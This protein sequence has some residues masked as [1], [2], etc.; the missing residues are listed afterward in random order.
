MR[1]LAVIL[2]LVFNGSLVNSQAWD[3]PDNFR[4][5]VLDQGV[6]DSVPDIQS[7]QDYQELFR[8]AQNKKI[9]GICLSVAGGACLIG[10]ISLIRKHYIEWT[11]DHTKG[12]NGSGVFLFLT[13]CA[14]LGVGIP[15]TAIGAHR[16]REY[17]RILDS[18]DVQATLFIQGSADGI[19]IVLKF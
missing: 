3:P 18:Y 14:G 13:G 9:L 5:I 4:P 16:Q 7:Y 6:P 12:G 1:K 17:K 2:F 8:K 19:G 10:G 11:E 15:L